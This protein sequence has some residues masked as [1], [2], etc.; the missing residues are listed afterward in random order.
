MVLIKKTAKLVNTSLWTLLVT[1][2]VLLAIY[3]SLG[4]FYVGYVERYSDDLIT[5]ANK[6]AKLDFTT[7]T[8]TAQWS[9]LS[10]VFNIENLQLA[11]PEKPDEVIIT[12]DSLQLS[13]NPVTTLLR[14]QL[15]LNSLI[16][17]GAKLTA[18]ETELGRWKIK[19]IPDRGAETSIDSLFDIVLGAQSISVT[20]STVDL[21][22]V[23]EST[24][25]LTGQELSLLSDGDF[26]RV[27]ALAQFNEPSNALEFLM[28]TQGDPR[29][30]KNFNAKAYIKFDDLDL[31]PHL[32]V[33]RSFGIQLEQAVLD[34]ELWGNFT[35]DKQTLQGYLA[36]PFLDIAGLSGNDLPP[37]KNFLF[38][39]RAE[40]AL[41]GD[42]QV[43][44]PE[45]IGS[46]YEQDFSFENLQ[47]VTVDDHINLKLPV[48][49]VQQKLA[50]FL[51]M[52]LLP[53]KDRQ[54]L[55]ELNPK[56][57]LKNINVRFFPERPEDP[58]IV[59]GNLDNVSID[60]WRS[61]PIAKNVSGYFEASGAAGKVDLASTDLS[62]EFPGVYSM[63]MTFASAKGSV[64][65]EINTERKRVYVNSGLLEL[66]D[67]AGDANGL[68]KLDL[69][70]EAE[71]DLPPTMDLVI[72]LVAAGVADKN[73]YIP[74]L[75]L[76]EGLR[77]WLD[78]SIKAG[79]VVDSG[80]IYRGSLRKEQSLER[81]SQLHLNIR[82][83]VLDYDP[84]WP[85]VSKVQARLFIDDADLDVIA[86]SATLYGMSAS[87]VA[88]AVREKNDK[89]WLSIDGVAAGEADD[90]LRLLSE[91]PIRKNVG[92]VFDDWRGT[93]SVSAKL[94]LGIPLQG[95]FNQTTVDVKASLSN[96]TLVLL[97]NSL[98]VTA[99]TGA[100]N[101]STQSGLNGK[102]IKA[103]LFDRSAIVD[104]S[105]DDN[106][107]ITVSGTG[108][109]SID[110]IQEW[111][112]VKALMFADGVTDYQLRLDV[113]GAV[114]QLKVTSTL[115]GVKFDLP[116]PLAKD[117]SDT[118]PFSLTIPL[119]DTPLFDLAIEN[120]AT[121]KLQ[122]DEGGFTGARFAL[123][124]EVDG[125]VQAGRVLLGG[126]VSR[127]DVNEWQSII[128]TY[129]AEEETAGTA[130][131]N[132]VIDFAIQDLF[133][134]EGDAFG[135]ELDEVSLSAEE[136]ALGWQFV[137]NGELLSGQFLLPYDQQAPLVVVFDK[138][139]IPD[140]PAEDHPPGTEQGEWAADDKKADKGLLAD[141]N[142]NELL[143]ADVLIN[144][145]FIGDALY[146]G[147]AF[148]MR[149]DERG[150]RLEDLTGQ[151]RGL[152]I[153][154]EKSPAYMT[155]FKDGD[156]DQTIFAGKL[157]FK[158]IGNVLSQWNYEPAIKSSRGLIDISL[159]WSDRPDNWELANSEGYVNV[160]MQKGQFINTSQSATGTLKLISILNLTNILRR[161]KLDFS[162]LFSDGV[163]YDK[164]SGDF[165]LASGQLSIVDQLTI[166]S[167]S[168]QFKIAGTTSLV[169]Q[170]LDMDLIATLPIGSNLPW[171]AAMVGGLPTAAGVYIAS[172]VFKKQ[173]DKFSSAVYSMEGTWDDPKLEFQRIFNNKVVDRMKLP[174][175]P[176]QR[177]NP[178]EAA[179]QDSPQ[180]DTEQETVT[181][182]KQ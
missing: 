140:S 156:G 166:E 28:E 6:I 5:Q 176:S 34:G 3:V 90:V 67:D 55:E 66:K 52:N 65:W 62:I 71:A 8:L 139:V 164:F 17:E 96:N 113:G 162:D 101:F 136:Q 152:T 38:D 108:K 2:L 93:G 158:N 59:S 44:V 15:Q 143:D 111:T 48:L 31:T 81:T 119:N 82:D 172:K 29:D 33:T 42:W 46:W 133:I 180:L 73:K 85:L 18:V 163:S 135:V 86:K 49:D 134:L 79:Q 121:G 56:G 24:A 150:L 109:V 148:N 88:V 167:S 40:S 95:D 151:I 147:L 103:K 155:W 50:K 14:N 118:K 35:S 39:I 144:K 51:S 125:E 122:F 159:V 64:G 127:A 131:D 72:G 117:P 74:D 181:E 179:E 97:D 105:T 141:L 115:E 83:G 1:G 145:L 126:S 60:S 80:Y 107:K 100:L 7:D 170:E 32:P 129:I 91:T 43:W 182:E 102:A 23:N 87:N 58:V 78:R 110:S 92:D 26:R 47:L 106:N 146:G 178:P 114:N 19:G 25:V 149:S 54:I 124:G 89:P 112:N 57:Q 154:S 98:S 169:S 174:P 77:G 69:P 9:G 165:E 142:P 45:V 20:G 130:T 76:D 16:I 104:I 99:I 157:R 22:F 84:Q 75:I 30:R 132:S 137:V 138:L 13:I 4:R 68:L 123:G 168:S 63:P 94:K 116:K 177:N 175:P 61:S 173:V 10:P 171:V 53:E 27:R 12:V 161:L 128:E 153:G 70:L 37:L 160:D 120:F 11:L 36:T 41:N 21:I